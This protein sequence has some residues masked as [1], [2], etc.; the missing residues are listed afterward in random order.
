[1]GN[2]HDRKRRCAVLSAGSAPGSGLRIVRVADR[3]ALH[4]RGRIGPAAVRASKPAF[5]RAACKGGSEFPAVGRLSHGWC[6]CGVRFGTR[7]TTRSNLCSSRAKNCSS[8]WHRSLRLS[9]DRPAPTL[10]VFMTTKT[11][12]PAPRH[13]E[14]R[15]E[16]GSHHEG[17]PQGIR[18]TAISQ[19]CRNGIW[20]ISI[21]GSTRRRSPA[22]STGSTPI[23]S[24]SRRTT[25]AS[26][27][28]ETAG[29]GG[30]AWLAD[31]VRRYEAI[32][33]L[34][35][36][37]GSYAGLV[38]AGD[39]VDP[40]IT[41]FYGDVSER[42]TTA[43][44]HLLFFALELNRV[45]DAVIERAMQTP[46]LGALSPVDRGQPQGQAVSARGSRRAAVP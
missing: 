45:D 9:P 18:Q 39:S 36:R 14:T 8:I 37:L 24:R 3:R 42:L 19:D 15:A 34:A 29:E 43:S 5:G 23:A 2:R 25:R 33:D 38:H 44:V 46:E 35:G 28:N 7:S 32:D 26:S 31:A 17:E 27:R 41:K 1:M 4:T 20:P 6:C 30:G 40:A 10:K 22:I 21:P 11:A 16:Q 12:L 13:P